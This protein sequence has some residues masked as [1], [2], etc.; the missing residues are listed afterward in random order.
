MSAL[1]EGSCTL[2]LGG[3]ELSLLPGRAVFWQAESTLFIADT[4]FGK[5][6]TFRSQRIPV[7]CGL[8]AD[9]SRLSLLLQQSQ[10]SRL[11][12]LGDLLHAKR[13]RSR[14]WE[15]R[16]TDWRKTHAEIDF[17]LIRGNHDRSAGDP[18]CRWQFQCFDGPLEFGPFAL[19]HEPAFDCESVSLCGHLHPKH[20]FGGSRDRLTL[21]CYLLRSGSLVLPAFGGFVDGKVIQPVDDDRFFVDAESEV[22]AMGVV[23]RG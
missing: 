18:P 22:V 4:H 16:V 3:A 9:L 21:L 5:E 23:G 6:A 13:G 12:V 11:V 10:A 1:L 7:P 2:E 8:E 14:D 15:D 17:W 20:R 19:R